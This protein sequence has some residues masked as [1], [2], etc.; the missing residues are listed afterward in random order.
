METEMNDND[1]YHILIGVSESTVNRLISNME[2]TIEILKEGGHVNLAHRLRI[3]KGNLEYWR[4]TAND[5]LTVSPCPHC[6]EIPTLSRE[7]HDTG[8]G[9]WYFECPCAVFY[10]DPDTVTGQVH[11][12][13]V[14]NRRMQS[15][16]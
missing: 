7:D 12:L 2:K 9:L 10:P 15:K 8:N 5:N 13:E 4:E 11:A 1:N 16:K 14:W 3:D 6:G